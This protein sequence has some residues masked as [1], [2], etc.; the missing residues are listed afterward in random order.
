MVNYTYTHKTG[1]LKKFLEKIPLLGIPDRVSSKYIYSLG[2]KSTNDRSIIPILKSLKFLDGSGTPTERYKKYRDKTVSKIVLGAAIQEM[3]SA[4]FKMYPN[5]AESGNVE[6]ENFFSTNTGLGEKAV[7]SMVNT[8][9]ALCSM[10]TFDRLDV[11]EEAMEEKSIESSQQ[12]SSL[13]TLDL[14][15]SQ[16][17]RARIIV[18]HDIEEAEIEKLK[19]LLDVLK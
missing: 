5:A 19:R 10:A 8:F 17:R 15:L 6:L 4:L 1:S 3:Y 14:T 13:H 7:K 12:K 16:G 18:P 11:A 9:K 2:F